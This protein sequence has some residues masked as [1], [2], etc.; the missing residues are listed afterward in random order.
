M[1]Q[2][3]QR[4]GEVAGPRTAAVRD[5]WERH[6]DNWKIATSA[7]GTREFFE[8][9]EAYRFEKLTYLE[10]VIDFSGFRG[11]T[12][13]E[14]GCGVA[15][16]LSRFA[17]G[18]ALVTGIDIAPRA[19][20]LARL[21]FSQRALQ[22]DFAIMDGEAMGFPDACFDA[23]YCHTVLHFTS[24]PGAMI[25]EIHRVLKPGG[26]AMLMMVNRRS[27]MN[28]LRVAMRV[29]VDHL[30]APEYH[31]ITPTE[32]RAKLSP[33]NEVRI[34][35]E[36]FPVPTKV[37]AGLKASLFNMIFVNTFNALPKSWTRPLGH[38]LMAF[39]RKQRN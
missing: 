35:P 1:A 27:W 21:N 28:L 33:F 5:Y 22:G 26:L 37:H 3:D 25:Q 18:G 13:L 16:D 10:S 23:V 11:K 30:D 7:P 9:I 19:I 4:T 14:V 36:R 38:H 31:R 12:L 6:V 32:F 8:E 20:E 24:N 39:C 17:R 15:N 29:E 2:T 34:T